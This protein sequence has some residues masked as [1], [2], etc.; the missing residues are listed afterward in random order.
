MKDERKMSKRHSPAPTASTVGTCPTL[1]QFVGRPGTGS[2][3]STIAPRP[4]PPTLNAL[5]ITQIP[6]AIYSKR[7]LKVLPSTGM[8]AIL[9][10]PQP[11]NTPKFAYNWPSGF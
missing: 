6:D 7:I 10:C 4:P 8:S 3:P 11:Q 2:L 9:S 1:F 5:G